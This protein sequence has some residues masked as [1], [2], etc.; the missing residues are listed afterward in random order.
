MITIIIFV[1]SFFVA[2][3]FFFLHWYI[4]VSTNL[5]TYPHDGEIN[6]V[7]PGEVHTRE[8]ASS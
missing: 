4:F 3:G 8:R 6:K 2:H 7:T 5:Y 1:I